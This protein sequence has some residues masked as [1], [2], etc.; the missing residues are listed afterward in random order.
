MTTAISIGLAILSVLFFLAAGMNIEDA[1]AKREVGR[2]SLAT[3]STKRAV[4]ALCVGLALFF[5]SW[6]LA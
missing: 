2:H 6:W 4:F 3:A 5:A 1:N